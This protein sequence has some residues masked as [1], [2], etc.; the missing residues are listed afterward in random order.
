MLRGDVMKLEDK[1]SQI[2]EEARQLFK[3][4]ESE[5]IGKFIGKLIIAMENKMEQKP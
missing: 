5:F 2:E 3:N 4:F 1:E